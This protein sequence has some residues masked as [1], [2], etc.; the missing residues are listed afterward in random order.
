MEKFLPLLKVERDVI[1]LYPIHMAI[2]VCACI[3]L[4]LLIIAFKLMLLPAPIDSLQRKY[5][6][7]VIHYKERMYK[8]LDVW[9]KIMY[10]DGKPSATELQSALDEDNCEELDLVGS[11]A[12]IALIGLL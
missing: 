11:C 12:V 1:P 4:L 6:R 7:N 3:W 2:L 8:H 5:C 9:L 10:Y